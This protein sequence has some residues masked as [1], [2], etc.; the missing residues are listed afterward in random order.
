M[1]NDE[2]I[3]LET[4][5]SAKAWAVVGASADPEKYGHE[6]LTALREAGKKVFPVNPRYPEIDGLTCYPNLSGLPEPPEVVVFA[7]AP[8]RSAAAIAGMPVHDVLVWL[9]PGCW[10]EEAVEACRTAG[11]RFVHDVC[12]VGLSRRLRLGSVR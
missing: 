9:P 2:M 11:R 8:E 6:V 10:S 12:P 1:R 3:G 4:L 5:K 7:L